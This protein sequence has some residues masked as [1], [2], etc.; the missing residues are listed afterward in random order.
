MLIVVMRRRFKMGIAMSIWLGLIM[1]I[2]SA[3]VA[4]LLGRNFRA[5]YFTDSYVF[6]QILIVMVCAFGFAFV[7]G[8]KQSD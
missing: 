4:A 5:F 7:F 2:A 3:G 6:Y 1:F 8:K